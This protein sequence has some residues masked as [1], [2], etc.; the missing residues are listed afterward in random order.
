MKLKG[1]CS[2]GKVHF[3]LTSKHPYP[4]QRCYCSI[5]RKTGGGGGYAINI[6][7][8]SKSLKVTGKKNI[9]VYRAV[10]EGQRSGGERNFCKKCGTSLWLYDPEWPELIHPMASAIDTELPVAKEHT[11]LMTEFKPKWVKIERAPKDLVF[12]RYPKESIKD[13]HERHHVVKS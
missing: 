7:G 9:K 13:W 1:S 4:Y 8:D 2:C 3:T 10:I 12:K 6:S 5:C 11:H